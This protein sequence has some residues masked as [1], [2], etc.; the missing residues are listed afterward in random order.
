MQE[1]V[2]EC[3]WFRVYDITEAIYKDLVTPDQASEFEASINEY[4]R[5]AGVGW[6]LVDGEIRTRGS[7]AFESAVHTAAKELEGASRPT[8]SREIHE[9]LQDLSRRPE[10]DLTGAINHA[11]GALEAVARYL[12]GESKATLGRILNDYPDLVPPPLDKALG[13]VW[14]YASNEARH[15]LEG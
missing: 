6:Q 2:L 5:E 11:M 7:E 10:P 4:F 12:T 13:K 1:L 9:A 14:G 8:A 15:I 3:D